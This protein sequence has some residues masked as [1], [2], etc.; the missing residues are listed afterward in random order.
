MSPQGGADGSAGSTQGEGGEPQSGSEEGD[1]EDNTSSPQDLLEGDGSAGGAAP[2]AVILLGDDYSPPSE[3]FYFRQ[4][5]M[6]QLKGARLVAAERS[7]VDMDR[8]DFFPAVPTE[9]EKPPG[10]HRTPIQATV[11]LLTEHE[12][13]FGIETPIRY[14]PT[15]NPHPTRFVRTYAFTALAQST[16]YSELLG[17]TAGSAAWSPEIW[18][19]YTQ[20]PDDPRYAALAQDLVGTSTRT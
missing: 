12:T 1:G 7:D 18:D 14:T 10:A 4:E 19:H 11:S 16:P 13:P 17:H 3:G 6:S 9:L 15:R 20:L 8:M 2:V 5:P